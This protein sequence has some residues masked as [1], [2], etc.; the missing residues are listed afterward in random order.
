ML[1]AIAAYCIV[2]AVIAATAVVAAKGK[3]GPRKR[4]ISANAQA[5]LITPPP[6]LHASSVHWATSMTQLA[7]V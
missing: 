7:G 4:N 6:C 3:S 5:R 1:V 2:L